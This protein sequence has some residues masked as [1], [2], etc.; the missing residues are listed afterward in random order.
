MQVSGV[1]VL[2][3]TAPQPWTFRTCSN[4]T[5]SYIPYVHRAPLPQ[6]PRISRESKFVLGDSQLI[7]NIAIVPGANLHTTSTTRNASV[8]VRVLREATYTAGRHERPDP[9]KL[10]WTTAFRSRDST[11][12]HDARR[13]ISWER[14]E[15]EHDQHLQHPRSPRLNLS[16][17]RSG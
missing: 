6:L 10:C 11:Y 9:K 12:A 8:D 1:T 7:I 14:R 5:P 16:G 17:I 15:R 4:T 2:L 13:L 3:C